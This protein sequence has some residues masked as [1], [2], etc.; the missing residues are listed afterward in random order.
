MSK[1]DNKIQKDAFMPLI[2]A[3]ACT[4]LLV[5]SLGLWHLFSSDYRAFLH[6]NAPDIRQT[7]EYKTGKITLVHYI[8]EQCSCTRFAKPHMRELKRELTNVNHIEMISNDST[9]LKSG[10]NL[11]AI[12]SPSVSVFSP[13]GEI[14]YHGPYSSGDVCGQGEDL[15]MSRLEQWYE[16]YKQPQ[17]NVLGNGC[18]CPWNNSI[19][20]QINK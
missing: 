4:W 8:D 5:A 6:K 7:P 14:L 20:K 3:L 18:F 19:D 10:L 15:V 9:M 17:F 13:E 2:W 1:N 12:S 16:G 11:W